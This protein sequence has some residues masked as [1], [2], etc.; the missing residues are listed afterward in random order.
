MIKSFLVYQDKVFNHFEIGEEMSVIY[1]KTPNLLEDGMVEEG[2]WFKQVIPT[3]EIAQRFDIHY[4]AKS[5][6]KELEI[7]SASHEFF[8]RP[9]S[10]AR[11]MT[12]DVLFLKSKGWFKGAKSLSSQ[13][14]FL[15]D[16]VDT[17][18]S[19]LTTKSDLEASE[20]VWVTQPIQTTEFN[21]LSRRKNIPING[22]EWWN[23]D[24]NDI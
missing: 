5:D 23:N 21:I 6:E 8:I 22:R 14:G 7:F 19:R 20:S 18:T 17:V 12:N 3:K 13:E 9:A 1:T 16:V 10:W 2:G 11:L 15:S 24:S 4:S